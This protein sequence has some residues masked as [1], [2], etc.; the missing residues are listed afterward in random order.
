ML[1]SVPGQEETGRE[2]SEIQYFGIVKGSGIH[3][4]LFNKPSR[5]VPEKCTDG[6]F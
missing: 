3:T 6:R 5:K 2:S 1:V 4:R